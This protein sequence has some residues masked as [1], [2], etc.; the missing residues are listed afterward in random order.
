[1]EV[2][3]DSSVDEDSD[4]GQLWDNVDEVLYCFI[5]KGKSKEP[6]LL[7]T[8]DKRFKVRKLKKD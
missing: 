3:F 2:S 8:H 4:A 1:M 6:G 5:A 7:T